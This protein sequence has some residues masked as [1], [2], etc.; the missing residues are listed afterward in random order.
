VAAAPIGSQREADPG[1]EEPGEELE[2]LP[3]D[4]G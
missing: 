4:D 3:E 2:V 1:D